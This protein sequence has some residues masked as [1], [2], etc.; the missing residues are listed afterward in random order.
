MRIS[1]D[2]LFLFSLFLFSQALAGCGEK[3]SEASSE[4]VQDLSN[5]DVP[6]AFKEYLDGVFASYVSMKDAFV[7]SD[8]GKVKSAAILLKQ[9][10]NTS[11]A[12]LL[13]GEAHYT[14]V[15]YR[16]AMNTSL[17]T[18]GASDDIEVQRAGLSDLSVIVYKILKTFGLNSGRAYYQ[19]CPMAFDNQGAYWLSDNKTIMNPYFGDEMLHCGS[20]KEELK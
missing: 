6:A 17:T 3:K 9:S 19:Y 16:E 14:W 8:A 11:A 1:I 18:I 10:L 12:D 7:Q 13:E 15:N 4:P 5:A 20:V 2:H